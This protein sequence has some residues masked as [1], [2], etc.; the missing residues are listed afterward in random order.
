MIPHSAGIR[1]SG[2]QSAPNQ[3]NS[4]VGNC[5]KALEYGGGGGIRTHETLSRLP[6]FKTGAFNHSATPPS[7]ANQSQ[8]APS[9]VRKTTSKGVYELAQASLA[10]G[11]PHLWLTDNRV[12]WQHRNHHT[13]VRAED[14]Q[15]IGSSAN[16]IKIEP[17]RILHAAHPESDEVQPMF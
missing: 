13:I 3:N 7:P 1:S 6:V 12:W 10:A 9:R 15:L 2:T 8:V 5:G 16:S 17:T 11:L 14:S 4:I